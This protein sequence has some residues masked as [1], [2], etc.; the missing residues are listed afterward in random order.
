MTKKR[1]GPQVNKGNSGSK[2]K[3]WVG[4][5]SL[6]IR[7]SENPTLETGSHCSLATVV[8]CA[9]GDYRTTTNKKPGQV[10]ATWSTTINS[11]QGR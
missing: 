11:N 10:K 1:T 5:D 6:L 4:T 9:L 2:G 3:I 8:K 7:V